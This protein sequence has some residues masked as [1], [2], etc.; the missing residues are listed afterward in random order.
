MGTADAGGVAGALLTAATGTTV[1]LTP[2][3][4]EHE[5][6]A[7]VLWRR[8]AWA[9]LDRPGRSTGPRRGALARALAAAASVDLVPEPVTAEQAR[10]PRL[11]RSH[12]HLRAEDLGDVLAEI[13]DL[14]AAAP[15]SP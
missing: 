7:A 6:V 14:A 11:R 5:T 3:L 13:D 4:L 1:A 8:D 10:P 15:A 9:R 12:H 2:A